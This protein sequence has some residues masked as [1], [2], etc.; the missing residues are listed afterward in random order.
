MKQTIMQCHD[1]IA[2][3]N[4]GDKPHLGCMHSTGHGRRI[5]LCP[6]YVSP[7]ASGMVL[8]PFARENRL[9]YKT[10]LG[11][12]PHKDCVLPVHM[13]TGCQKFEDRRLIA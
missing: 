9:D 13:P 2:T 7:H 8:P 4:D 11:C 12:C 3:P 10:F 6:I 5:R 1:S